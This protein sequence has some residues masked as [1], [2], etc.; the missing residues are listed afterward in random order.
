[1]IINTDVFFKKLVTFNY[2]GHI[3]KFR[4]SQDLFSSHD[5]DIG[6]KLLLRSLNNPAYAKLKK[7]L[8]IGCGYGPIGIAL[9]AGVK[10]RDIHMVDR[11]ALAVEYS[12]QNISL[13]EFTDIQVYGSLGYDGVKL[14]DLDLI[15]S[16]IPAKIGEKAISYFLK[17]AEYFLQ[18]DGVVAIVIVSPL[19]PIVRPILE[20]DKNINILFQKVTPSYSV[21]H[22]KF[23]MVSSSS[24]DNETGLEKGI[25]T[26]QKT[27]F[28]YRRLKF[29][30]LTAYG[31]PEFDTLDH[32]TEMI[33]D[34]ILNIKGKL[35]KQVMVINT[36]QGH[37]PIVIEKLF[38]PQSI[39]L[40]DR[41]LLCLKYSEMNLLF[42]N[43]PAEK[44]VTINCVGLPNEH[45]KKY[46]LIV[47]RLREDEGRE[48][49]SAIIQKTLSQLSENGQVIVVSSST[50]IT[51]LIV[52]LSLKS[53][54]KIKD[55]I[56]Y[57]GQSLLLL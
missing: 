7:I 38:N 22:Y 2:Y 42:N 57:K 44:T 17:K 39:T 9:K 21:Y 25:Y 35:L 46:D 36:G 13:N 3:L 53:T 20:S 19:E 56:Q 12:R 10:D 41:D 6:T 54:G 4:V 15:V 32:Q 14:K 49:A 40:V 26:R 50:S 23:K 43:Y 45:L 11:D 5:I 51:R 18:P 16:N 37:I 34:Y 29:T 33:I 8:D 24:R 28:T 27:D 48:A 52:D 55:R 47:V 30:L 1:M 31:L